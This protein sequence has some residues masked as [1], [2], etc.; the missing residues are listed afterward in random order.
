MKK[1]KLDNS[2]S[3]Y[4]DAKKL[5]PGGVLGIRRPYNFVEGEYPIFIKKGKG[6]K[7]TDIDNNEYID[8]LCSYG[9]IIIGHREEKI[10]SSVVKQI[11][12]K[13][14]C[15]SLTQPVNMQLSKLLIDRIPSCEMAIFVKSGSDATSAAIRAAR[16]Y[17]GKNKI[18]RCGYHGWHDWCVE[19]SNGVTKNTTSEILEFKYNDLSRIEK[20]I[21]NNNNDIAGL[22]ITPIGHQLGKNVEMPKKNYLEDIREITRKNNIVLIFDE[23]RTGFR[24]NMGGAQKLFN[25]T[26]DLSTFGKAMANGYDIASLVGKKEIMEV[27]NEK[28]FISSTYF[29][30]S[31]AMVASIE[32]INFLEENKVL[33]N[34]SEKG[35]YFENK[36]NKF[37]HEYENI[38]EFSGSPWMPFINFK[39][40]I[41]KK[42]LRNEFY[43]NLIN[44]KVFSHPYHH[45]YICFRHSYEDLDYVISAIEESLKDIKK[46]I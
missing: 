39:N 17:T 15:F 19:N 43:K 20:H 10:D 25:V 46:L 23:I 40:G 32:T 5:H 28:A 12:E 4:E 30:N 24:M 6:C 11:Q 3:F 21:K 42:L 36:L 18:L 1:I 31:L 16:S 35:K 33:Q 44:K 29:E 26:P 9:P 37:I 27:Y 14:F 7:V 22:I 45:S 34:I 2:K 41:K 8:M 38:C 13:G